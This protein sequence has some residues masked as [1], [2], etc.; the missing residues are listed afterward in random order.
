[1]RA[2]VLVS[3]I[4]QGVFFRHETYKRAVAQEVGGWVKNLPDGNL[5]AVFEG[6]Q[7][8]VEALIEWCH[9][10]PPHALVE[11]LTVDWTTPTGE[12]GFIIR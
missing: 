12:V 7:D 9:K 10:G 5:E 8:Q 11:S 3:G 6:E 1:M 4:V 2:R